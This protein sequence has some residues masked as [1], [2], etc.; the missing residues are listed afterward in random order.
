MFELGPCSIADGG[1]KTVSNPYSWNNVANIIFLDQ[2]IE[3]GFSYADDGSRVGDSDLAAKDVY[4]FLE[5]FLTRFPEYS[6]LPF[7][8]AAES[9][10]GTYA[11]HIASV[12]YQE[13]QKTPALND[14]VTINLRSVIIGNGLTDSAT[15]LPSIPDYLCE[16][17]YPLFDDPEGPQCQSLRSQASTCHTLVQGCYL[18][19]S[20]LVCTPAALY[21]SRLYAPM[22][23][24]S[25]QL[26]WCSY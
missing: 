2:P 15:Q 23:G 1:A 13:N 9:Y 12:I 4:A 21:C 20:R 24:M 10:G 3:V 22:H 5:L 17:P 7:H 26:L 19:N 8:L 25:S 11:P 14:L 16:G 6:A 18:V